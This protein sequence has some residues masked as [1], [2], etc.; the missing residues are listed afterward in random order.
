[1]LVF[2]IGPILG[3]DAAT[4]LALS[5]GEGLIETFALTLL[6]ERFIFGR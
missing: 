4:V 3:L 6:S 1:M 5:I 2:F